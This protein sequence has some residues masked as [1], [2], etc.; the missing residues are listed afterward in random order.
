MR[1]KILQKCTILIG[2]LLLMS[3]INLHQ[4]SFKPTIYLIGDSTM[5]DKPDPIEVS[6]ERGW[7]QLLPEFFNNDIALSNHALNGRSSESFITEGHWKEVFTKLKKGDY[8][9]IQFGHNDEK[10]KDPKRYTIP[11]SSYYHNLEKFVLESREKGATPIIASSI[12]RRQFNEFG[13]LEDT[14]GLYPLVSRNVASDLKVPFIDLQFETENIVRDEGIEGS[15][16]IYLHLAPGEYT[17]HPEGLEDN[18]HLS[19]YGAKLYAGLFVKELKKH[20]LLINQ[21]IKN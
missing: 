15:K 3:G 11:S 19:P 6:P 8:V 5:A 4:N 20:K 16:K 9:I 21:F 14:H 18:T 13:T 12:V 17:K 10:F 2:C 1:N 7:G